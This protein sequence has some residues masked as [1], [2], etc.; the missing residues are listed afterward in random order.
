MKPETVTD[1]NVAPASKE[2]QTETKIETAQTLE[3][4]K[5]VYSKKDAPKTEIKAEKKLE[6]TPEKK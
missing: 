3:A 1:E 6:N 4:K 5:D 2:T